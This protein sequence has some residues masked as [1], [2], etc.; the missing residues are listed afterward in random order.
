[1][2]Y[3]KTLKEIEEF[4]LYK[5]GY[6]LDEATEHRFIEFLEKQKEQKPNIELIQRSWYME[7]YHDG[8][9]CKEPK[10]IIKTGDGGPK[11]E[12]NP[13]YG[14]MLEAEQ[15]PAEKQKK[16]NA[17]PF[18]CGHEN[19][20]SEKQEQP[21]LLSNLD[22]AAEDYAYN[23]WEDNDYH[24]GASEGLP[25][26]AIGHTEKCFK[27]GAY[28]AVQQVLSLIESRIEEI[29]GDAQPAPV[30][31]IELRELIDKIK[32]ESK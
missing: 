20:L 17:E 32:E 16:Q 7:G 14:Q 11:Y 19:G 30:L 8:K 29:L 5:A 31:R 22:E 1:M 9:F 4:I 6:L 27:A 24:T 2:D 23:N 3:E 18:S 28:F 26:D 13:K 15:K 10:W 25:F 12:E 21:S